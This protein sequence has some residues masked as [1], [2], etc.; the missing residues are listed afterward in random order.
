MLWS[1]VR[2]L[3]A[4]ALAAIALAPRRV[5]A[6]SGSSC[7]EPDESSVRIPRAVG[8]DA[9]DLDHVARGEVLVRQIATADRNEVALLGA[10][11]IGAPRDA[12]AARVM[13][14]FTYRSRDGRRAGGRF[15]TPASLDDVRDLVVD[16]SDVDA[17]KS[18]RRGDCNVKLPERAMMLFQSSI[19]WSA[20]HPE[21]AATTLARARALDYVTAYRRAGDAALIEYDD[22]PTP[23]PA[24]VA[25]QR[26]LGEAAVL[27]DEAPALY[28][29]LRRYPGDAPPG[30]RDCIDW[31][32]DQLPGLRPITSIT[33][34]VMY[35]PPGRDAAF[36]VGKQLY[37]SH[38]F[39]GL[40]DVRIVMST[41]ADPGRATYIVVRRMLFDHL[42]S[43]GILNTRGRAISRLRDGLAAELQELR[44][45]TPG[46]SQ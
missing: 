4:A 36:V 8:L 11:A 32:I 34:I 6:Q 20:P 1:H 9:R 30:L 16:P 22:Q 44:A 14:R 40:L 42:P 26:L 45:W 17:V 23:A 39:E 29:F 24:R 28:D 43:G 37:A 35:A 5:I 19:D 46:A 27:R 10:V 18:C 3:I 33:H 38:Y 13:R 31:S 12:I 25:A 21:I 15:S 7:V 2:P 41:P